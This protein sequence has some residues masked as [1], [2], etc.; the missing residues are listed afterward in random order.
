M[1][2]LKTETKNRKLRSTTYCSGCVLGLYLE[3]ENRRSC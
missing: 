2:A 3:V 1:T